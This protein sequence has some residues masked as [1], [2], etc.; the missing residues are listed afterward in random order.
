MDP[1]HC[2]ELRP[3]GQG[4]TSGCGLD[5]L[6]GPDTRSKSK[7][8]DPDTVYTRPVLNT[9]LIRHRELQFRFQSRHPTGPAQIRS[10]GDP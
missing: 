3:E 1:Q 9:V 5:T 10:V 8:A 2:S 7:A 6:P 4:Y